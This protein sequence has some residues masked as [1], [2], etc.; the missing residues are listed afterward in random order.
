MS[1]T[2]AAPNRQCLTCGRI[3]HT[4]CGYCGF[5][6][7]PTRGLE[8]TCVIPPG[9]YRVPP[10]GPTSAGVVV[11]P[12][13]VFVGRCLI[14]HDDLA[15]YLPEGGSP[16][17]LDESSRRQLEQTQ[18][19]S[20]EEARRPVR[21]L[22]WEA[23]EW[24]VRRMEVGARGGFMRLPTSAEWL[25]AAAWDPD[26][27]RFEP[28]STRTLASAEGEP[29][30][31]EVVRTPLGCQLPGGD[32]EWCADGPGSVNDRFVGG[33][34]LREGDVSGAAL[35]VGT[36]DAASTSHRLGFRAAWSPQ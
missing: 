3:V 6:V 21:G 23:A 11:L 27:G 16:P 8:E 32:G 5:W 31:D 28:W 7:P 30:E 12:G 26:T 18:R 19:V 36:L 34:H 4:L 35:L 29:T 10:S 14:T 20:G 17:S 33:R 9:R 25:I 22:S 1:S 15:P 13:P 2:P 24:C